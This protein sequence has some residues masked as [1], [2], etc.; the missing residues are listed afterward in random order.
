MTAIAQSSVESEYIALESSKRQALQLWK[1]T[2]PST[3][4][5]K[6]VEITLKED[7]LGFIAEIKSAVQNK[8]SNRIDVYYHLST[9]KIRRG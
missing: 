3:L 4:P 7:D 1:F 5:I 8:M 6:M 9:I 2:L